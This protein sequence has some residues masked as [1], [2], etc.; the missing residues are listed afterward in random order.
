M[1]KPSPREAFVE[2]VLNSYD[3]VEASLRLLEA[4]PGVTAAQYSGADRLATRITLA[5]EKALE[6]A[7]T[8]FNRFDELMGDPWPSPRS[9]RPSARPSRRPSK[10]PGARVLPFRRRS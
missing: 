1:K 8:Y 2:S 7:H 5:M 4:A 9:L 10:A 3:A 6:R